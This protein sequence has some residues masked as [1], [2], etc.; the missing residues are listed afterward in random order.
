[1]LDRF[2]RIKHEFGT[3][4]LIKIVVLLI[5]SFAMSVMGAIWLA[6]PWAAIIMIA[7][8][9]LGWLFR[10][11]IVDGAES[12]FRVV[13]AGV[14]I[15]GIVLTA[16]GWLGLSRE[17]QLLIITTTSIVMF[18]LQFWALSDPSFVNL[19]REPQND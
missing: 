13:P 5:A 18:N 15:Y 4:T 2:K 3:I 12:L 14:F 11:M 7:G 17:A 8:L 9:A 16:G 6:S 10:R 1:M 19:E